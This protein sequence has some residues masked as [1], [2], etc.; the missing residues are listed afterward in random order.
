MTRMDTL[1]TDKPITIEPMRAFPS[2]RDPA[3]DARGITSSK[4]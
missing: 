1:N 3:I 2:I 4:R